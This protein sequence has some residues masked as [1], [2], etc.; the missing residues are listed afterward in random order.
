MRTVQVVSLGLTLMAAA[1]G[2]V[3]LFAADGGAP[4]QPGDAAAC[5]DAQLARLIRD[6][7]VPEPA[8]LAPL[9]AGERERVAAVLEGVAGFR[10]ALR[11][12][13]GTS[14]EEQAAPIQAAADRL[15][16]LAGVSIPQAVLC[17]TAD[18]F[19]VYDPID[20]ARF[21][22]GGGHEA[23]LYCE[24][25]GFS[26][27]PGEP[28][29]W[30]VELA[31][32]AV[33]YTE[34]GLRVWDAGRREVADTCRSRRRDFSISTPVELPAGLTVGRYLLKVS[35]IDR[36]ANRVA[37]ATVPVQVVAGGE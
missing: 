4:E 24:V 22:R 23:V 33:L 31:Q 27:E 14:P 36:L 21:T 3:P 15:R 16:R 5:L 20:P 29:F 13:A 17:R 1:A 32:E 35:V 10:E 2:M 30:E 7:R 9:S 19:G 25:E 11:A 34:S 37:E 18:G 8:A 26:M 28:G 12:N 6:E